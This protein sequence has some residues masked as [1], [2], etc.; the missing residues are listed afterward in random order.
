MQ[1][2]SKLNLTNWIPQITFLL[3]P[4]NN[5]CNYYT[6]MLLQKNTKGREDIEEGKEA[7]GRGR[8]EEEKGEEVGMMGITTINM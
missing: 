6:S 8:S 7:V 3:S 4:L 1:S 5:L 2:Q